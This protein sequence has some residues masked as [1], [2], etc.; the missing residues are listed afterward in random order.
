VIHIAGVPFQ[1]SGEEH[2]S[3][4]ERAFLETLNSSPRSA[5]APFH[6][7]VRT[8]T[9]YP[10]EEQLATEWNENVLTIR[11]PHFLAVIDTSR[12]I[13]VLERPREVGVEGEALVFVIKMI[14]AAYLPMIG[15]LPLHSGS[16]VFGDRAVAFFGPSGAGKTTLCE[17]SPFPVLSDELIVIDSGRIRASGIWGRLR[18]ATPDSAMYEVAGIVRI[19]QGDS[20]RIE[21]LTPADSLRYMMESLIGPFSPEQLRRLIGLAGTLAATTPGYELTWSLPHPDWNALADLF[22]K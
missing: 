13:A 5:A 6:I 21:P 19:S 9:T 18:V 16:I 22:R 10:V 2:L 3:V 15:V 20:F 7:S 14:L 8:L 1:F 12:A 11:H 17:S 4:R